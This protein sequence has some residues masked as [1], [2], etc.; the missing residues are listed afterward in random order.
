M[1]RDR[2]YPTDILEA[3]RLAVAYVGDTGIDAFL[4][5]TQCQ[6]AVVRRRA[7]IGEADRRISDETRSAYPHIPWFEMVGLRNVVI[8]EY[9]TV[10]MT[11]V[12]DTVK[13]DLPPLIS[14]IASI[15]F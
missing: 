13:K 6:D 3:A 14:A 9:D 5:D 7:I 12:W 15:R 4:R 2:A 1:Q 10:D 11:V 8:H